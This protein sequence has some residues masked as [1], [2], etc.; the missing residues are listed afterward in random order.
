MKYTPVILMAFILLAAGCKKKA[1]VPTPQT[2]FTTA[3]Y[4]FPLK[5]GNYWAYQ[6]VDTEY[7]QS[8]TDTIKVI[9]D[10]V[11]NSITYYN[12][13]GGF[14]EGVSD[15]YY[16][17]SA[18]N[19]ISWPGSYVY[20]LCNKTNDTLSNLIE[21]VDTLIQYTGNID[22]MINVTAGAFNNSIQ[23]I[24]D[25]YYPNAA[26]RPAHEYLYFSKNIGV[27]YATTLFIYQPNNIITMKLTG[28][29]IS[30]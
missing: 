24:T 28:Y 9:S 1:P 29:H 12:V 4:F 11:I 10:T 26:P 7:N 27:T 23:A 13:T 21:G 19:I 14:F 17:D 2:V 22:T 8:G 16:G 5:V 20:R 3:Q 30:Q 15:G 18:G 6:R 25:V